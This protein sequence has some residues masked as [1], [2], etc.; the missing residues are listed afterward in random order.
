MCCRVAAAL[1]A[2][3]SD[4]LVPLEKCTRGPRYNHTTDSLLV[5]I[6]LVVTSTAQH[7]TVARMHYTK[8]SGSLS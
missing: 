2:A 6:V 5:Q 4:F 7:S 1:G 3:G 8:V